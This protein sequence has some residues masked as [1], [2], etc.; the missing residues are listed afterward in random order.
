[1]EDRGRI[2]ISF[3]I[4]HPPFSILVLFAAIDLARHP[5]DQTSGADA[6]GLDGQLVHEAQR[7]RV[8]VGLVRRSIY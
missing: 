8:Q 5:G 2:L 7:G 3:A 4:F 6:V 1:M